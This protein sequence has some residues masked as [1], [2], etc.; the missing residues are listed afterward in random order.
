[1]GCGAEEGGGFTGRAAGH[2]RAAGTRQWATVTFLTRGL[3]QSFLVAFGS[4][5][6]LE[7]SVSNTKCNVLFYRLV[8][9]VQ[10]SFSDGST[11]SVS[12][13]RE[14]RQYSVNLVSS[15][16]SSLIHLTSDSEVHI[17]ISCWCNSV[18]NRVIE[19]NE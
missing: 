17:P 4:S 11:G 9:L 18:H 13:F 8:L 2:G 10:V 5:L 12:D 6:F 15:R 14:Q 7:G 3:T 19:L 16:K 1:M